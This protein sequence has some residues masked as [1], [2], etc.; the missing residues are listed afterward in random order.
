[1]S[2]RQRTSPQQLFGRFNGFLQA[3]VLRVSEVRDLG[4]FN[5]YQ[6][7]EHT[8]HYLASLVI[9]SGYSSNVCS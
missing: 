3:V 4:D 5:R 1:V 8:K 9:H 2:A 6:F 7:Y